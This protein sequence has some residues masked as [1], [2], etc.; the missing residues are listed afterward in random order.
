EHQH[1]FRKGHSVETNLVSFT[2][3]LCREIDRGLE[4]D[5]IYM[6][7][8]SAFDKVCHSRLINKLRGFGFGG[9]LLEWFRSYLA[10]RL[11]FVVVNGH[12]SQDYIAISGVPQGSHLG[13]VLFSAFIND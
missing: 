1:G 13:P 9:S 11:Q 12:K 3:Y 10:K 4:V 2:S 5:T 8:S 7:F 6:D